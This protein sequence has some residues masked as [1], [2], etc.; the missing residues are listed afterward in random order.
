VG[1]I[2][3]ALDACGYP[4]SIKNSMKKIH[5]DKYL[6]SACLTEV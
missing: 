2:S 1:D 4:N 3:N 6:T 5:H